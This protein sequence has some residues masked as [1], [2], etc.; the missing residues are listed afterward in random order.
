MTIETRI[1]KLFGIKY[2]IICGCMQSIT[3]GDFVATIS[4][5]GGMGIIA[6]AIFPSKELLRDEIRKTKDLTD[7]P[8]AV[9][10][11]L[12]P[13]ARPVSIEEYIDVVLEEGVAVIE[14]SGRSPKP[15]LERIRQGKAKFMHKAARARDAVSAERLGVDAVS[16]V[17]V[18]CAGHPGMDDITTMVLV[19][20]TAKM[21]SIPV[22]AGG[23]FVNGGGLIAALALGAEAIIM[24][25][26][27]LA[28]KECPLHDNV[29]EW[30]L[31]AT[32]CDTMIIQRT[33]Q[34]NT[35]VMTNGAAR[36]CLEMESRGA[37]LQ[38]LLPVISGERGRDV[39]QK[40]QLDAGTFAVG[41][42]VGLIDDVPTVREVVESIMR[43]A[44]AALKKIGR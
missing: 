38:E 12:F 34:S 32:E 15:Y 18:E 35:R 1:T 14:T 31:K 5:A 10:V 13:T 43:E 23:G 22:I 6:S 19:P 27:F 9:N 44:E 30:M 3:T 36:Q 33:I 7:K 24:G 25:T 2:P 28:T 17:G 8:F 21:V 41:Q 11:N 42:A 39:I 40:G 4:N 26:R 20:L 29:K 16:I 37:T